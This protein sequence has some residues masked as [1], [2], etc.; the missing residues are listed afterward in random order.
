MSDRVS[1]VQA[2][3]ERHKAKLAKWEAELDQLVPTLGPWVWSSD[4]DTW[5]RHCLRT[6]EPACFLSVYKEDVN[7][8]C[9]HASGGLFVNHGFWWKGWDQAKADADRLLIR[10]G[11]RLKDDE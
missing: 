10:K 4:F 7:V 6:G 3:I 2:K 5:D 9:K 1:F 8:K 11:W